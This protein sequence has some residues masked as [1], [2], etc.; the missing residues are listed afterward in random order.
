MNVK[1]LASYYAQ[2]GLRVDPQSGN[3]FGSCGGYH[4]CLVTTNLSGK[5]L[6]YVFSVTCGGAG[7]AES[8][9]RQAINGNKAI[10]KVSVIRYRVTFEVRFKGLN[11]QRYLDGA[12]DEMVGFLR[13]LGCQDCCQDCGSVTETTTCVVK[14]APIHLCQDCYNRQAMAIEQAALEKEGTP[15]NVVGGTV[16]A[17]LGSLIGVVA[18]IVLERLGVV[19]ALSG[20]VMAVCTLKGYELIS[21]KMT[22]KG[23][24]ISVI[25]MVVMVLVGDWIDWAVLI[26]MTVETDILTSLSLVPLVVF[27][28]EV[29]SSYLG[30]LALIYVFTALGAVPSILNYQKK[31]ANATSVYVMR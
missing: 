2:Y 24:I 31:Q 17:L 5:R 8:A 22:R 23:T 19:S 16:G 4:V 20:I 10:K 13:Q 11:E 14:G 12:L 30:N 29:V 18:I 6:S 25:V 26:S 9:L 28:E 21:G 27:D 7:P 1:E 15:E 3:L